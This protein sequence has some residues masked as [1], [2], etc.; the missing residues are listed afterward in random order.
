MMKTYVDRRMV[1]G[2]IKQMGV[3]NS[4]QEFI[5]TVRDHDRRPSPS[6]R[7][8]GCDAHAP[9]LCALS[10]HVYALSPVYCAAH[11][12]VS[13]LP[14]PTQASLIDSNLR[15]TGQ[16]QGLFSTCGSFSSRKR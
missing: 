11:V 6:Y 5:H 4:L 7:G 9:R 14:C 3:L 1:E 2:G 15:Q 8:L 13:N 16:Y 12:M 10:F